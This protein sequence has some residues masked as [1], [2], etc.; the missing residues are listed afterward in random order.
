MSPSQGTILNVF[1]VYTYVHFTIAETVLAQGVEYNT[2]FCSFFLSLELVVAS[3]C[4]E[5]DTTLAESGGSL[6]ESHEF[7]VV[8]YTTVYSASGRSA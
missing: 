4:V 3:G 7:H 6:N 2:G 5:R 8:G 1:Q